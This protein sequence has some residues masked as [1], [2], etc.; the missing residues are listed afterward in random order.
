MPRGTCHVHLRAMKTRR[1][2]KP[3]ETMIYSF[4]SKRSKNE[5]CIPIEYIK[6]FIPQLGQYRCVSKNFVEKQ[7][8]KYVKFLRNADYLQSYKLMMDRPSLE[9]IVFERSSFI[10]CRKLK[11]WMEKKPNVHTFVLYACTYLS[12]DDPG[13]AFLLET[14]P[15][16][17]AISVMNSNTEVRFYF[18]GCWRFFDAPAPFFSPED[19]VLSAISA[20][21]DNSLH[22]ARRFFFNG[23][24]LSLRLNSNDFFFGSCDTEWKVWKGCLINSYAVVIMTL[25]EFD[26]FVWLLVQHDN[27]WKIKRVGEMS[28]ANAWEVMS[29][30]KYNY[31]NPIDTCNRK[32]Y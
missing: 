2:T 13:A 7:D 9:I 15:N 5:I 3:V 16:D 20:M 27:C 12:Q 4:V 10:T 29:C 17:N 31:Y 22:A 25:P 1:R 28:V 14:P 23:T 24:L 19:V 18:H 8:I 11:C 30:E 32:V 21:N 6:K 26:P